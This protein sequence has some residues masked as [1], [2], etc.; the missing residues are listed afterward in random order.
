MPQWY[1]ALISPKLFIPFANSSSY[2]SFYESFN[3]S[4]AMFS[5]SLIF[6]FSFTLM[7]P[8]LLKKI[9]VFFRHFPKHLS[10]AL[11]LDAGGFFNLLI[12]LSPIEF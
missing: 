8:I 9:L 7:M 5:A 4:K 12:I 2:K 6:S 3:F 11:L 1:R 10:A